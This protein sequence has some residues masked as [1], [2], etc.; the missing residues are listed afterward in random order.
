MTIFNTRIENSSRVEVYSD[1]SVNSG[2]L[3]RR[4][5]NGTLFERLKEGVKKTFETENGEKPRVFLENV[6]ILRK[7]GNLTSDQATT[8]THM[9]EKLSKKS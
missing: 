5:D 6:Q 7:T 8:L 3:K 2:F 9:A 1:L 4:L